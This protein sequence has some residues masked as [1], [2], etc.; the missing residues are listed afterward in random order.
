M[1][2]ADLAQALTSHNCT[3]R[4]G[5][6]C[7]EM[8]KPRMQPRTY[9]AIMHLWPKRAKLFMLKQNALLYLAGPVILRCM[10]SGRHDNSKE[11]SGTLRRPLQ[12]KL[13]LSGHVIMVIQI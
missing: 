6:P 3:E 12:A 2:Y 1:T 10:C 11:S 7:R 13:G 5:V 4:N 8:R 9:D